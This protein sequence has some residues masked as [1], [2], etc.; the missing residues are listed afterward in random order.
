MC[1]NNC[2]AQLHNGF[3]REGFRFRLE[4]IVRG[5]GN[6]ASNDGPRRPQETPLHVAQ[7]ANRQTA[8]PAE[9]GVF[10]DH[11]A[12]RRTQ[13]T[14]ELQSLEDAT[15]YNMELRELLA[16]YRTIPFKTSS[17]S[18]F[19]LTKKEK[20]KKGARRKTSSLLPSPFHFFHLQNVCNLHYQCGKQTVIQSREAQ[21]FLKQK[22]GSEEIEFVDFSS[23]VLLQLQN[24]RNVR[25]QCGKQSVLNVVKLMFP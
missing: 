1:N 23:P 22:F 24:V 15:A 20:E 16:R 5:Q 19:F 13:W 25:Y 11:P 4:T 9:T 7:Q 3:G 12:P 21:F 18:S 14:H 8:S 2:N 6:P 17:R 10:Q